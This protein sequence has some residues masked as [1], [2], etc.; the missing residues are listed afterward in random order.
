MTEASSITARE[1]QIARV[2]RPLGTAP[3]S[4]A[5]AATAGRLLGIHWTSVYRLRRRFLQDPVASALL[6]RKDG[7]THDPQRLA[8]N[9]EAIVRD[10]L[11]T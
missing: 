9:V 10:V 6:P 2:L 4:R 7:R 8:G 5:Q 1:T 11:E 3:M